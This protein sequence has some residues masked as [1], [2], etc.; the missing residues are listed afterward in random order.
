M[1]V[2]KAAAITPISG[3]DVAALITQIYA[4]PPETGER[5]RTLL[6]AGRK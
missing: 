2:V 3:E 4:T 1:L 5:V 6:L